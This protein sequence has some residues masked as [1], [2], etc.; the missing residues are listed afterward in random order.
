MTGFLCR[1]GSQST[2][3]LL[4]RRQ[5]LDGLLLNTAVVKGALPLAKHHAR[6]ATDDNLALAPR[7]HRLLDEADW[8]VAL[9]A[10]LLLGWQVHICD[11]LWRVSL[12]LLDLLLAV[13]GDELVDAHVATAHTH[14]KLVVADLS[15][16]LFSSDHVETIAE[17][18]DR[19]LNTKPVQVA[20]EHLVNAVAFFGLVACC[21][22]HFRLLLL[23]DQELEV[24]QPTLSLL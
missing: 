8:S 16:D 20:C 3:A 21:G 1:P 23:L 6:T 19:Q 15:V 14:E 4:T 18:C 7:R 10:G 2:A 12:K 9:V 13:S 24:D 22:L 5:T 11:R 17:P